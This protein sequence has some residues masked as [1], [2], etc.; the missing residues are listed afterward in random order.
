MEVT[1]LKVTKLRYKKS[2]Q[3]EAV[4]LNSEVI[5][6]SDELKI[7]ISHSKFDYNFQCMFEEEKQCEQNK[8]YT[9]S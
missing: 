9:M 3:N 5:V 8:V 4:Q 2:P 6:N 7:C 1:T